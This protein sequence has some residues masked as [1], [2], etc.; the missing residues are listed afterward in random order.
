MIGRTLAPAVTLAV[1]CGCTSPGPDAACTAANRPIT[2]GTLY[3]NSLSGTYDACLDQ[4]RTELAALRL[5]AREMDARAAELNRQTAS[6][7]AVRAADE[8]R[9]A[10]VTAEQADIAR[11]ISGL[12]ETR[13]VNEREL[14]QVL[15]EESRLRDQIA[16]L[17]GPSQEQ[18]AEIADRQ[19]AL[20][21]RVSGL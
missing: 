18:A 1:L 11:S 13:T 16:A 6:A 14:R 9:L 15:D 8:R 3:S 19:A 20:R 2:L 7:S 12:A 21:E 4:L 10:A 17:D 5:T